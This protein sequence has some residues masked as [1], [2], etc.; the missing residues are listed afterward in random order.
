MRC[1][2]V[3]A[4]AADLSAHFWEPCLNAEG[5]HPNWGLNNHKCIEQQKWAANWQKYRF[6]MILWS[7]RHNLWEYAA[8]SLHPF[9][10]NTSGNH[11]LVAW[12]HRMGVFN[13][14]VWRWFRT[15]LCTYVIY[16]NIHTYDYIYIHNNIYIYII[17]HNTCR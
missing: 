14:H 5:H 1:K 7:T 9:I 15:N 4:S 10:L 11:G 3:V 6:Y 16:H 2:L 12:D 13:I 8:Q 17:Y